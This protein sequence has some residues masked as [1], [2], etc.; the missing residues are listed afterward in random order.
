MYVVLLGSCRDIFALKGAYDTDRLGDA[1]LHSDL[2][3]YKAAILLIFDCKL[4]PTRL[5]KG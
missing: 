1:C 3:E 4:S 2:S 5:V